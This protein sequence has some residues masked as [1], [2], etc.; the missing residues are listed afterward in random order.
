MPLQ[1]LS[2]HKTISV[3]FYVLFLLYSSF[4]FLF[5]YIH[6]HHLLTF[7]SFSLLKMFYALSLLSATF[8]K[9]SYLHFN[10]HNTSLLVCF[11]F[12]L[13]N[14]YHPSVDFLAQSKK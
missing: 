8:S 12:L 13:L 9:V 6:F 5:Y 3:P 14:F 4:I 10:Y 2:D 11:L 1:I 7:L